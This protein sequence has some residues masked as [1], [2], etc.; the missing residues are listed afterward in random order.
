[1]IYD[2]VEGWDG[3][4][5]AG[6]RVWECMFIHHL[7]HLVGRNYHNIVKQFSFI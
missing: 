7:S 5:E 1:M 2:D 6:S 3:Q 4:W